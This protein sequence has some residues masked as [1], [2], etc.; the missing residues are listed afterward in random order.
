MLCYCA[1]RENI[2]VVFGIP[3][4]VFVCKSPDPPFGRAQNLGVCTK[5][6]DLI[7][8]TGYVTKI[9]SVCV[10]KPIG[11][12]KR[13]LEHW[14]RIWYS[15]RDYPVVGCG[16]LGSI[17]YEEGGREITVHVNTREAHLGV[18]RCVPW[19]PAPTYRPN[20]LLVRPK[21][22]LWACGQCSGQGVRGVSPTS[23]DL[24]SS[25]HD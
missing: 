3:F 25:L 10:E 5:L 22:R 4:F 14:E 13:C 1:P 9:S 8:G 21:P 6:V 16:Y 18:S 19:C 17:N 23:R 24:E 2:H 15:L 20:L 11:F 12:V 7:F